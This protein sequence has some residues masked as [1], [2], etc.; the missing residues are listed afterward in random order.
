MF[1]L[2]VYAAP[3]M[4]EMG[5]MTF[6]VIDSMS[7]PILA[8][9]FIVCA[10]ISHLM[11]RSEKCL[12]LP[13]SSPDGFSSHRHAHSKLPNA[14]PIPAWY[15]L[16]TSSDRADTPT[17]RKSFARQIEE[18]LLTPTA[19]HDDVPAY[20]Y[21]R[22]GSRGRAMGMSMRCGLG[23]VLEVAEDEEV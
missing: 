6:A 17:V 10:I 3:A 9:L 18:M 19:S 15:S 13:T 8:F 16:S 12:S 11:P 5:N 20:P 21:P 4:R 7:L 22:R 1:G 23:T 2:S 14:L